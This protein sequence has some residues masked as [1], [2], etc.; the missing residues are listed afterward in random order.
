[1]CNGYHLQ[2]KS[3]GTAQGLEFVTIPFI[4]YAV[5]DGLH[6]TLRSVD[7]TLVCVHSF[8]SY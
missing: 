2:I 7:Y 8:E 1:M 6:V 4:Y 3:Y 5:Q